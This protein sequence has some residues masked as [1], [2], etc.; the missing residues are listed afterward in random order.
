MGHCIC[1]VLRGQCAETH[2]NNSDTR[3][4]DLGQYPT[5]TAEFSTPLL[6]P[7]QLAMERRHPLNA[8]ADPRLPWLR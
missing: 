8:F 4:P 7:L 5:A 6:V 2:D 1:T 3:P